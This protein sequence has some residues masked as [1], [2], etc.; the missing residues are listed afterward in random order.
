MAP[1]S[2]A[3]LNFSAATAA[4]PAGQVPRCSIAV[5][6]ISG[7][8]QVTTHGYRSS[9]EVHSWSGWH[10]DMPDL[11][12]FNRARKVLAT[13][14]GPG[15][16]AVERCK[17]VRSRSHLAVEGYLST[18]VRLWTAESPKSSFAGSGHELLPPLGTV[19]I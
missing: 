13:K 15:V 9:P 5:A 6:A 17:N 18:T 10:C 11:P 7:E 8:V 19:V 2:Y 3:V 12:E 14:G 1:P 16:P 4:E